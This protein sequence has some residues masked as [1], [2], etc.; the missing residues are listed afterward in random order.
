MEENTGAGG[1]VDTFDTAEHC[2]ECGHTWKYDEPAHYADCRFFVLDEQLD[3]EED[4][5]DNIGWRSYRIA[6]P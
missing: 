4:G 3:D 2:S 6:L 1:I 5:G